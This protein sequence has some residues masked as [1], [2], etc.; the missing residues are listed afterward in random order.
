VPEA[1]EHSA[2]LEWIITLEI[3]FMVHDVSRHF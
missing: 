2:G 3:F 1:P